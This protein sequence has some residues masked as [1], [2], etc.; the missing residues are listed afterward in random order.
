MFCGSVQS[1]ER[2]VKQQQVRST[3]KRPRKGDELL[4]AAREFRGQLICGVAQAEAREPDGRVLAV[5]R[6]GQ[7]E[8]DIFF[9]GE[10]RQQPRL[11]KHE[12]EPLCRALDSTRVRALQPGDHAQQARFAA[13]RRTHNGDALAGGKTEGHIAQYAEIAV[14]ERDVFEF[15]HFSRL[16]ISV[17]AR[18]FQAGS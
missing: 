15:K 5:M 7:N 13:A 9:G 3:D 8:P 11:L 16:P 12:G 18:A 1:L 10:P 14:A 2:L 17:S 4:H 6:I